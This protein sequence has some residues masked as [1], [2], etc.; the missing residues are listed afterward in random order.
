MTDER[1]ARSQAQEKRVAKITGGTLNAGSGNGWR[2]KADVR[3][4]GRQGLLWEMKTTGKRQMTIKADDL[5]KVR[6]EAWSDGRMPVFHIEIGD[7][8][9]VILEEADFLEM[10]P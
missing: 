10:L 3:S 5:E 2:R 4:G 6:K 9:Y 8:R 1:I 7:R